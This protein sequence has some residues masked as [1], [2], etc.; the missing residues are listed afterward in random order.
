VY[1]VHTSVVNDPKL[2]DKF[3]HMVKT[4]FAPRPER[5]NILVSGSHT[6]EQ[7]DD[8]LQ[9]VAVFNNLPLL[10]YPHRIPEIL[11]SA[12]GEASFVRFPVG[13]GPELVPYSSSTM[14]QYLAKKCVQFFRVTDRGVTTPV[15]SPIHHISQTVIDTIRRNPQGIA[16]MVD[17]IVQVP[18]L[19]PN[20]TVLC[21]PGYDSSTRIIYHPDPKVYIPE[22]P[23]TP[24]KAEVDAARDLV[25]EV[26]C[27]FPFADNASRSNMVALMLTPIV[28]SAFD[29]VVPIALLNASNP[30]S[31]KSYLAN[32]V[33]ILATGQ[34]TEIKSVP[35]DESEMNRV[36]TMLLMEN[37]HKVICFDNLNTLLE[38]GNLCAAITSV[39]W[40][41]RIIA[42]ATCARSATSPR[43]RLLVTTS[44]WVETC[45]AAVTSST[46]SLN[47]IPNSEIR[48]SF[49]TLICSSGS[50]ETVDGS[51]PRC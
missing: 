31:G 30:G 33:S 10:N 46:S 37:N 20:G 42:A 7:A 3:L 24:T 40:V 16:H 21:V 34:E 12:T 36:I 47:L 1:F 19:R 4:A 49:V 23:V 35:S 41:D 11:I 51:S 28:R 27:D 18:V 45:H 44:N 29:G 17:G 6:D 2:W 50:K 5:H 13:A 39:Y 43:G 22:I 15:E 38:S 48:T 14:W 25:L 32:V 8:A 26:I 9:A